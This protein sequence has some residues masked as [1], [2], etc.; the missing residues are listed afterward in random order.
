[1]T[2]PLI[3][4]ILT[5]AVEDS[6]KT[7]G[8][9]YAVSTLGG[10]C[11][12]MLLGFFV[13][14]DF[15]IKLP[16]LIIAIVLMTIVLAGFLMQKKYLMVVIGTVVM[17]VFVPAH[18]KKPPRMKSI[19]I[20]EQLESMYGQ[21]N[22]IDN[23]HKQ[24]RMLMI[25]NITQTL[26]NLDE[27]D[28]SQMNYVHN[29]SILSSLGL[30]ADGEEAKALLCGLGGGSILNELARM[31]F[32]TDAVEI[33]SR[34]PELGERYFN[35]DKKACN[36]YIDDARHFIRS[37]TSVYDLIVIDLLTSE[38]Q[39]SH[40]FTLE[41]FI[42]IKSLLNEKGILVINFQG[43][44]YGDE[45][46][47]TRSILKTLLEAQYN[48]EVYFNPDEIRKIVTDIFFIASTQEI[49]FNEID[50]SRINNCCKHSQFTMEYLYQPESFNLENAVLLTD[51][52]GP[53]LDLF[54]KKAN[55]DWRSGFVKE[56]QLWKEQ[57]LNVPLF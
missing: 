40:V 43:Y 53:I 4:S 36:I 31:G 29:L 54:N 11:I 38:V 28:V 19:K 8:R 44:I 52:N 6:G 23:H 57:Q 55:E 22:I 35:F 39:P 34:M 45:G 24:E 14:P 3:I 18:F 13:I 25:N 49:D 41:N 37:S 56:Y 27:L 12:I 17:L 51:D 32:K 42:H 48:V 47:A 21:I 26:V 46:K 1:M 33:D 50:Y 20:R 5:N 15:G 9:I 30:K 7:A 16:L 10:I 2:P